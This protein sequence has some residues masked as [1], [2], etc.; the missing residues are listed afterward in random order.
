MTEPGGLAE[1]THTPT[2]LQT[3]SSPPRRLW[4]WQAQDL[5]GR[6]EWKLKGA[7]WLLNTRCVQSP[8]VNAQ[9]PS[10]Q[11]IL[12][13][14]LWVRQ[15]HP[16]V[17]YSEKSRNFQVIQLVIHVALIWTQVCGSLWLPS[18]HDRVLTTEIFR[19]IRTFTVVEEKEMLIKREK[20][21]WKF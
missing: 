21:D 16:H 12:P 11:L 7:E 18:Y 17:T 8:M 6:A 14:T 15:C 19:E 2:N 20:I 1:S 5:K 3:H 10:S 4:V 13:T 9:H